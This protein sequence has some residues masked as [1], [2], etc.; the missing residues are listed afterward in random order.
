MGSEIGAEWIIARFS[1]R[2]R[3]IGIVGDLLETAKRRGGFWLSVGG[4]VLS[5]IW[6]RSIAF[7]A[8]FY[9]GLAWRIFATRA[10]YNAG[11]PGPRLHPWSPWEPLFSIIWLGAALSMVSSYSAIRYGLRDKFVHPALRFYRMNKAHGIVGHSFLSIRF[12]ITVP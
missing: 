6:R 2:S 4:I 9:V 11:H 7:I 8:A 12:L 5:L 1:D 3:A 10:F